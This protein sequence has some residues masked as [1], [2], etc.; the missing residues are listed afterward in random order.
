MGTFLVII[1]LGLPLLI[2]QIVAD[3]KRKAQTNREEKSNV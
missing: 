3:H 2:P 1:A